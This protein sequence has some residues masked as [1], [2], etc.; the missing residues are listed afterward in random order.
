MVSAHFQ[1]RAVAI[2]TQTEDTIALYTQ[3]YVW[4]PD[5]CWRKLFKI[6]ESAKWFHTNIIDRLG[7][8]MDKYTDISIVLV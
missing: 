8:I 5:N 1:D 3:E 7:G 2:R 4:I 6:A